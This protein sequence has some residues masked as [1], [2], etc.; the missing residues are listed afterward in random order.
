MIHVSFYMFLGLGFSVDG[1]GACSVGPS[2]FFG[3][4][5]LYIN[6]EE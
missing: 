6:I 1:F 5:A 2:E 4:V 3:V